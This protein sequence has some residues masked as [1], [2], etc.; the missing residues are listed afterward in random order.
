MRRSQFGSSVETVTTFIAAL[1]QLMG[2]GENIDLV[3]EFLNSTEGHN[4]IRK[5]APDLLAKARKFRED[6]KAKEAAMKR[7]HEEDI[8]RRQEDDRLLHLPPLEIIELGTVQH[9]ESLSCAEVLEHVGLRL[10][11][12]NPENAKVSG[13][14]YTKLDPN[15]Y[16]KNP[17]LLHDVVSTGICL[18]RFSAGR[19]IHWVSEYCRSN[20]EWQL[21]EIWNLPMADRLANR[22][23]VIPGSSQLPSRFFGGETV[24]YPVILPF[25]DNK[26]PMIA[27]INP[28]IFSSSPDL[29]WLM[30]RVAPKSNAKRCS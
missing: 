27:E 4:L 11:E 2:D 3:M 22:M 30:T 14:I 6:E 10:I 24:S 23:I 5:I 7:Q 20:P 28:W 17:R 1:E 25:G 16:K 13:E 12:S 9:P 8:R 21:G 18:L 29:Y 19:S 26:T 15:S